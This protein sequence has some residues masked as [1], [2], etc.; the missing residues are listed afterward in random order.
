MQDVT[1]AARGTASPGMNWCSRCRITPACAGNRRAGSAGIPSTGDHPRMRGEQVIK[2][3]FA[4]SGAGSP[5]HARGTG[6]LDLRL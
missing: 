3:V 1:P 2:P 5:P 4:L 6:L